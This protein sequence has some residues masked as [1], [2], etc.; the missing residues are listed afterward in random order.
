[1]TAMKSALA[2]SS[3]LWVAKTT[4]VPEADKSHDDGHEFKP[5]QRIKGRTRLV[6]KN[7]L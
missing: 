7:R 3:M 2:A 6:E 1:M 4:V 5:G